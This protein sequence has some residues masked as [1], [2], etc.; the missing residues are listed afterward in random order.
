MPQFSVTHRIAAPVAATYEAFADIPNCAGRIPAI[1][2]IEMLDEGPVRVGSRW[3]ETRVMYGKEHTET[4]EITGMEPGRSIRVG[5]TSCGCRYETEFRF[6]TDGDGTLVELH[7]DAKA[8][9]LGAKLMTP[10]SMLMMGSM[11]KAM[12]GDMTSLGA[13]LEKR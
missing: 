4:L 5:C 3:R 7:C 6:A 9:T 13:Y 1:T 12:L 2:R 11:K 10:L 8:L